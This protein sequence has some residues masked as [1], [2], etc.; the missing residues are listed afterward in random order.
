MSSTYQNLIGSHRD[1]SRLPYVIFWIGTLSLLPVA[2]LFGE[3]LPLLM[4]LA[5][6][7]AAIA[8]RRPQEAAAVGVLYLFACNIL[9]PHSARFDGVTEPWEMY[10]WAIG[11]LIVTA[12]GVAGVGLRRVLAVPLSARVFLLAALAAA[13]YG[14]THG[15][16]LSYASRQL[17]GILLLIVYLGIALHSGDEEL[18]LRRIRTFGSILAFCFLVYYIAVF[19]QYGFHKEV[20]FN[21]TEACLLAIVIF[22]PGVLRKKLSWILSAVALLLIPVLFFMRGAVLT[23]LMTLPIAVA[24]KVKSTKFKVLCWAVSVLIALPALYPPIAQMAIDQ[25]SRVPGMEKFLPPGIQDSDTLLERAIQLG[26]AL[27]TVQAH[28]W[29]GAGL[30]SDIEFESPT[31]GSRQVAFVDSGWAYLLQKM[32]VVGAAAFLWFLITVLRGISKD[33][34]GLSAC[35]VSA[36]VVTLFSQPVFFHFTSSPFMGSFA[37][38][39]LAAQHRRNMSSPSE[40]PI[41]AGAGFFSR[42]QQRFSRALS[43]GRAARA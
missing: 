2:V 42:L 18:L 3:M 37:G 38:L 32:G 7:L 15:A 17:Y 9:L 24:M 40:H 43:A 20:G 19:H 36:V 30:G 10:Y 23:F 34:V 35:L 5:V 6:I 39:L 13:L 4:A 41:K 8:Y 14:L 16:S 22:I 25:I 27:A 33:S 21:G 12:G 29:L 1:L 31:Q 26:A 28:P 11:L